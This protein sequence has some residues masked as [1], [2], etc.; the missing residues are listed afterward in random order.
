[1]QFKG[2]ALVASAFVFAACGGGDSA[3]AADSSSANAGAAESVPVGDISYAPVTG[4]THT[5]RM[6]YDDKG[7]RFDPADLTIKSGDGIH[8]LFVSG[9]PHNVAFD[10]S[11]LD[12]VTKAQLDAN[13]GDERLSELM[14][15]MYNSEGEGVTI[16]F[17][18]IKA[19]KYDY[20]CTPHIAMNMVGVITVE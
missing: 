9:G 7:Y 6:V 11:K 16:S 1:M 4:T 20:N 2:L 15:N 19:G 12:A 10:G 18:N 8:F 17:A 13:F 5:I 14:S 3:P